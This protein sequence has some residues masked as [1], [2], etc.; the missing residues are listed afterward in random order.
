MDVVSDEMN[1]RKVPR[2]HFAHNAACTGIPWGPWEDA[3]S[4]SVNVS[5]SVFLTSDQGMPKLVVCG[6]HFEYQGCS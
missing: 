1:A 5:M 2:L 6:L 4:G 3:D